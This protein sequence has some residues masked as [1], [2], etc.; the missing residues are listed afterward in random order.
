MRAI[1]VSEFGGPQVLRVM[2]V[3]APTLSPGQ[4]LV[5]V[6]AAGVN[7]I[8]VYQ[9]S[10]QYNVP[11]PFTPGQEGAGVVEAV[12]TDVTSVKVGDRVAWAMFGPSYAEM[13]SIP[14]EKLVPIPYG[15]AAQDAAAALL[16]GMT[17][18]FLVRSTFPLNP[19][20]TCL[21]HAAAGGVG[22]L[23]VQ[24]ARL[25]G[26]R[27]IGTVSTDE[28]ARL[29][30]QAGAD[31]VIL[32]SQQ[33]FLEETRRLTEGRGV[34]VVYDSVG[35]DTFDRSLQCLRPRGMLVLF[36]QSSGAVPPVDPQVLNARGSLYLTRPSLAHHVLGSELRQRSTEL[37]G[38]ISEG[39]LWVRLDEAYP[40]T[41]AS[42]A[43]AALE[44]RSTSGKLVLIP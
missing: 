32:Y 42:E 4:A 29:A 21:V 22:L 10:G 6:E 35:K 38:L 23:L 34:D 15:L 41:Q 27:V 31:E 44:S 2:D 19:G 30:R 40:L 20:H 16:Q 1:Q 36:G 24:L 43:H 8:D 17:A 25:A 14:V 18:H 13:V 28:K 11:L 9:R 5:R 7:F 33:D 26:A 37:F 3:A 39:K 12:G